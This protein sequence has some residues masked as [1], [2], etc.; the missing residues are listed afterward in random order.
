[1]TESDQEEQITEE[2]VEPVIDEV[3]EP[4]ETDIEPVDETEEVEKDKIN[5]PILDADLENKIKQ[6]EGQKNK[7]ENNQN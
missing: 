5:M 7:D 2:V 3:E 4:T 6:L 1:M